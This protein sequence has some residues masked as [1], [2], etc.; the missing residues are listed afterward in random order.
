M[1]LTLFW[2]SADL[3][4]ILFLLSMVYTSFLSLQRTH[5]CIVFCLCY[6]LETIIMFLFCCECHCHSDLFHVESADTKSAKLCIQCS[7]SITKS[8]A[9]VHFL[10]RTFRSNVYAHLICADHRHTVPGNPDIV[11]I[12]VNI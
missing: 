10:I 2:L 5:L 4:D 8:L 1:E 3:L 9:H 11:S 7:S 12:N 6:S